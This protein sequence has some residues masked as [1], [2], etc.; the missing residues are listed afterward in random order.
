METPTAV[1]AWDILY[2]FTANMEGLHNHIK[3]PGD[4]HRLIDNTAFFDNLSTEVRRIRETNVIRFAE[5]YL[6]TLRE[7]EEKDVKSL[8]L[9]EARKMLLQADIYLASSKLAKSK[10]DG[11]E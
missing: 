9:Q 4:L 6:G 11:Q 10:T 7:G 8:C 1:G 5:E 2:G 3:H